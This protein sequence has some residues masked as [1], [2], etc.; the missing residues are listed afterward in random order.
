[1]RVGIVCEGSSDYPVLKSVVATVLGLPARF[2]QLQPDF[3]AQRRIPGAPGPGWQ[4]VRDFL[5]RPDFAV[6]AAKCDILVI[7][8]DADVR[9]LDGVAPKLQPAA[10]DGEDLEPL[11]VHVRSWVDGAL[12]ESA[13]I[14]LP[15]EATDAWLVAAHT[16]RK[17]VEKIPKP[18][19]VLRDVG[20][21]ESNHT[22][23]PE[24]TAAK[25]EDLSRALTPMI[26][27]AKELAKEVPELARFVGK[28]RRRIK[29]LRK[30]ERT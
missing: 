28:I 4:G 16:N 3:D 24:K 26:G 19:E 9:R 1:V 17:H 30:K 5:G 13:I 27:D 20:L 25:Y 15:R 11:C 14:A 7:Q 8:V 2:D 29:T 21:L 18:A 6:A 22:R 23:G 12:P 10:H